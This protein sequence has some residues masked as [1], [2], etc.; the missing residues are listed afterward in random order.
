[1]C[2]APQG[3][4]SAAD[5]LVSADTEFGTAFYQPAA[6]AAGVG[7]NFVVSPYSVSA[8]MQMVDV[9]AAGNTDAQIQSV[10]GLPTNA[11]NLAPAYA[12]VACQDE[13]DGQPEGDTLSIANSLW[14][15]QGTRFEASFLSMLSTGY[16]APLQQVD[17]LGNP[18]AAVDSI[19]RWV[20]SATQ[21]EIPT[22]L[23]PSNVDADTRLVVVDAVYFKGT[24][25]TGFDPNQTSPQPFTLSDG[26]VVQVPTMIGSTINAASG[27]GQDVTIYE[28]PYVGGGTAMDFL[29]PTL[30]TVPATL[31]DVEMNLTATTLAA[32]VATLGSGYQQSQ[33]SLPK[34]SF[35][36]QLELVATLRGMGITD[37]FDTTK[38][39]F[40]GMDGMTDLSISAVEQQAMVEVDESG[41]VAAAATG[42]TAC[43]NCELQAQ[44]PQV[45]INRPFVFL[46][47]NTR[48]GSILF[49]GRVEDPRAGS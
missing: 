39:D 19:N 22:I 12:A 29:L 1:M 13:T 4:S 48:N 18:T 34:F 32:A 28:I 11:A 15:Q 21:G 26:T 7:Q 33:V 3:S 25:E 49:M 14:G 24:W 37:A 46:I 31:A 40:S 5:A 36:T 6:T 42:W 41:T 43:S 20:S 2:S 16:D 10:L 8:T 38:A 47:R 27:Y 44:P 30:S 45:T 35:T 23:Q 9:G 17:F